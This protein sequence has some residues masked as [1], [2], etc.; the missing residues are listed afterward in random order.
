MSTN[1]HSQNLFNFD[2]KENIMTQKMNYNNK[3]SNILKVGGLLL[4]LVE[5][6]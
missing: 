3:S 4:V 2:E 6:N 5:L 1:Q